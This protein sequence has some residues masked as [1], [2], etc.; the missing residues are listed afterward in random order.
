MVNCFLAN[1]PRDAAT[2]PAGHGHSQMSNTRRYKIAQQALTSQGL[3]IASLPF[4]NAFELDTSMG[5]MS[6]N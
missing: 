1:S 5:S 6:L 3:Y 2:S 4:A